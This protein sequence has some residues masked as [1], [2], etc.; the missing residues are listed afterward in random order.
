MTFFQNAT[1]AEYGLLLSLIA[2]ITVGAVTK[3]AP[4]TNNNGQAC[5][6][7]SNSQAGLNQIDLTSIGRYAAITQIPCGTNVIPKLEG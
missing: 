1:L 6:I 3:V 5:Q 7:N 4:A 2:V